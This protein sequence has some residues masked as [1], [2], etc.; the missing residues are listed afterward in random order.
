MKFKAIDHWQ[1]LRWMSWIEGGTLLLL[2]LVAVPL[3]RLAG[4]PEAVSVVGPIHGAAFV[5][6]VVLVIW[7][8]NSAP[9]R[10]TDALLLLVAAFVPLG[11]WGLGR[12]FARRRLAIDSMNAAAGEP[13]RAQ[14]PNS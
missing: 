14:N 8:V 4:L 1:R 11:A 5:A 3:K 7:T 10:R 13:A 6:Y 9:W 12:L 2:V